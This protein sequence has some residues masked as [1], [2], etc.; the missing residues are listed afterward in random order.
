MHVKL[1]CD[2]G[3]NG[4]VNPCPDGVYYSVGR[5]L[6]DGSCQLL[7][8]KE[9]STRHYTNNEAEYL[10]LN[11]ALGHAAE[12]AGV[13]KVTVHSDS[14]LIVNQFNGKWN[15]NEETLRSLMMAARQSAAFLRRGGVE[16][17]VVWVRR[18]ENV[19]RLGH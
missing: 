11:A 19:K 17:E 8:A 9:V 13:S 15:C 10:A 5:D 16:V 14:Q 1:F 18:Q 3:M 4:K 2:G 7:T 6:P 12:M